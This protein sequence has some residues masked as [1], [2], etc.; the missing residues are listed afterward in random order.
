MQGNCFLCGRYGYTERHHIFGGA[1]RA[2]SERYGLWVDLCH[3]CHNEPPT[4]VHHNAKTML[5]LH[6]YGQKKAMKENNW[7]KED[8]MREFYKNYL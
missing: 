8:F 7:S 6:Q 4:G 1:L 3:Y 2:K 5:C